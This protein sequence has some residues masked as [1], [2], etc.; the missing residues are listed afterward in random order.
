MDQ[1]LYAFLEKYN[2]IQADLTK[3]EALETINKIIETLNEG[4]SAVTGF[5][6]NIGTPNGPKEAQVVLLTDSNRAVINTKNGNKTFDILDIKKVDSGEG[7]NEHIVTIELPNDQI[8]LENYDGEGADAVSDILYAVISNLVDEGKL[9]EIFGIEEEEIPEVTVTTVEE[10]PREKPRA[11][12]EGK[13]ASEEDVI[14]KIDKTT[15]NSFKEHEATKGETAQ[16]TTKK[17]FNLNKPALY[18]IIAVGVVL[19]GI[20]LFY[21]ISNFTANS[22][23]KEQATELVNIYNQTN[24]IYFSAR[25]LQALGQEGSSPEEWQNLENLSNEVQDA[26]NSI[27]YTDETNSIFQALYFYNE[28]LNTA[29]YYGRQY[30]STANQLQGNTLNARLDDANASRLEV[31]AMIEESFPE[32]IDLITVPVDMNEESVNYPQKDLVDQLQ[33]EANSTPSEGAANRENTKSSNEARENSNNSRE[34]NN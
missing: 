3:E 16:E 4:E 28:T 20:L 21:L 30:A 34:S 7:E 31:Y 14:N 32:L 23:A 6:S 2:L 33:E 9:D 13:K 11:E 19:V 22:A 8:I 5:I 18:T 29:L 27:D 12:A 15:S 1:E 10:T 24:D 26:L 25:D 17:K